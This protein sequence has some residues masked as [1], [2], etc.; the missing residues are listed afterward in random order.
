[1]ILLILLGLIVKMWIFQ[2]DPEPANY[3]SALARVL[4]IHVGKG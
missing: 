2:K 4:E 3:I 1:M